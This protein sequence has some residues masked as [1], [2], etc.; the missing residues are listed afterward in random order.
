VPIQQNVLPPEGFVRLA[1]II[2]PAG[3]I[4]VGK[5]TWWEGVRSGRFPKPVHLGRHTTAWRVE[6]IRALISQLGGK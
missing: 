3:P 1:Q 6:D 4:P 2:K 5:S